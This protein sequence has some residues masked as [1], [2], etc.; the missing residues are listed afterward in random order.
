[1]PKKESKKRGFFWFVLVLLLNEI[2]LVFLLLPKSRV[3]EVSAY[4]ERLVAEQLNRETL[5]YVVEKSGQAFKDWLLDTGVVEASFS[6]CGSK[7]RD[8]FD[9]RGLGSW[10]YKRITVS[11]MV[12]RQMMFRWYVMAL[13]V[14]GI[15]I[16]APPLLLDGMMQREI[17]KYQLA[18]S[19]PA[20]Q[21]KTRIVM[22][23]LG[24]SVVLVPL[25]PISVPPMAYPA[26]IALGGLSLWWMVLNMQKRI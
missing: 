16:F 17:R 25:L 8:R 4:E 6:L 12:V 10:L 23:M 13:W 2:A 1:M 3:V 20:V 24:G 9:D 18:Y 19:S 15:V 26:A 14:P 22:L 7:G 11:W 21:H 5:E